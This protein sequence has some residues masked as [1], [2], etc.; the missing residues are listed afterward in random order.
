MRLDDRPRITDTRQEAGAPAPDQF[1][2][3]GGAAGRWVM[4]CHIFHHA[5]TGMITELVVADTD[6][7]GDGYDT[8]Q[9]CNDFDT[10]VNPGITEICD[11]GIDNNCDGQIDE[12]GCNHSP[13][14]DAGV[15]RVLDCITT[16]SAVVML[17]GTG[18]S[19]A[20]SDP[21]SFSWSASGIV[22]DDATSPTPS[23]DFPIGS[24]GV[25]LTVSDGQLADDD[26]VNIAVQH[27]T[28]PPEINVMLDPD[29]LWP[30]NHKMVTVNATVTVTD[31]CDPA[32]VW[33]LDAVTSNEP[34]NGTGDG[35]T[36]NDIQNVEPGTQDTV[37]ELRAER[38][39]NGN[40]RIYSL[41]YSAT[42][43]QG[44]YA[45]VTGQVKVPHS[46]GN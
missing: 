33:K 46:Q 14:A 41:D 10:G 35:D 6:R 17:D 38:A 9:D 42:D 25:T 18:S 13:V 45:E 20:D 34:D 36:V 22:F 27:D 43:N 37:Y 44:N 15:D 26:T 31:N 39:G 29:T 30:P 21:L 2:A 7:D 5:A 11:D 24:T 4:H 32:P 16:D 40:G 28:M 19:D 12:V 23:A 1:F 8:S 3:S